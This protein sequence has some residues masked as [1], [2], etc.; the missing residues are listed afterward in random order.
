MV[1][2][3]HIPILENTAIQEKS[4]ADLGNLKKFH[5]LWDT[6]FLK[7]YANGNKI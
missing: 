7:E 4:G 3:L 5:T 1:T 2:W 6:K